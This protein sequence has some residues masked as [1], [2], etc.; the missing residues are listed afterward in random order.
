[1]NSGRGRPRVR[2]GAARREKATGR[3]GIQL[4][5]QIFRCGRAESREIIGAKS[6]GSWARG[7]VGGLSSKQR[8]YGADACVQ[9]GKNI[10]H[11]AREKDYE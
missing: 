2:G 9:V 10:R 1:M 5:V 11:E 8:N 6:L 4:I 7:W 3:R